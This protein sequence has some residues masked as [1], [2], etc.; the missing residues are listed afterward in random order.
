MILI[1]TSN[2]KKEFGT[3]VLFDKVSFAIEDNDKIGFVGANGTGKTTLFKMLTGD[4]SLDG[5]EIFK[6]KE[7]K[8]G[9][10]Q[11]HAQMNTEKTLWAELM[12]V[13]K[14]LTDIENRLKSIES[15]ITNRVGDL[16]K[17]TEEQHILNEEYEKQG[18]FV[19]KNIAKASLLGLG[20]KEEEFN[21]EF[22]SL[23]GGQQTRVIL[24]KLLLGESNILLLDEPTN[25]LD[26]ESTEWLE[27]FLRDY[28]GAFIVISHDRYFLDRV[29]NK[30]FEL[31]N[32]KL[33]VYNANYSTYVKLKEEREK[34]LIRNYE[35]TTK[36]IQRIE[37][38]I[39]QQKRW[40]REK[41][42][43][44]AESKQ[45]QIDRLERDLEKPEIYNENIKCNRHR[46]VD[47]KY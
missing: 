1:N 28:K 10:M 21:M 3:R 4:I 37:G 35:N 29:T 11:Q 2:L 40:N 41:N 20:F 44:T 16:S 23:S 17:L 25:H 5:G 43:K 33:T 6:S 46:L 7:T 12:T 14:P 38:I 45:K 18:G 8:L 9:Y 13:Y 27:E 42:I 39:E 36:E 32:S 47:H 22:S 31:E 24:C 34:T 19:Y 15:Q 26:I 30:T